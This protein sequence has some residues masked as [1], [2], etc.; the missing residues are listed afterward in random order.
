MT[1][2]PD[3]SSLGRQDD[4]VFLIRFD[5]VKGESAAAAAFMNAVPLLHEA[6]S[7]LRD[8]AREGRM[9]SINIHDIPLTPADKRLIDRVLGEGKATVTLESLGLSRWRETR[10]PG[11]WRCVHA[12]SSGGVILETLEICPFPDL[13]RAD[14]VDIADGVREM[15]KTLAEAVSRGECGDES[16]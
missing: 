8:L 1:D 9:R 15:E 3:H 4:P 10:F 12:T 13:A 5:G 16:P 2:A 7:A 14:S 11:L 6:L